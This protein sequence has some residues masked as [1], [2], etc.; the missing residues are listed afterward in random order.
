[1]RI[2]SHQHFWSP[3][4]F[5]YAWMPPEPNVLRREF[6]P[7][8]LAPILDEH[9]FDGSVVVQAATV[10]GE[11]D[12][13]LDMARTEARILGVVA[14]V[15]LTGSRVGEDLDHLAARPKFC[16]VR[17]PVHD[18]QDGRWLLRPDVLRG[19]RELA[20][21]DIPYDLLL[22]PPH[23]SLIPELAAEVPGLRMVIDHIAKPPIAEGRLEGWR[24]DMA[25]AAALPGV[26]CKLSGMITEASPGT[27]K[28]ADLAP[29][30]QHALACFGP[31]RL[32]FGSDWPVCL[33]AG[34]WKQVLAAFT[35]ALGAQTMETREWILGRTART[36]YRLG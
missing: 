10:A 1:M 2:D 20:S 30:V 35:Q 5:P 14:W 31:E 25:R 8:H 28:A 6:L 4:R 22:R 16:G 34:T 9:R 27:W 26:H 12:W 18:E 11:A 19:L 7:R 36:F 15:D 23:L 13:L 33:L 29:F 3:G 32:M 17:H 21:R 24:E